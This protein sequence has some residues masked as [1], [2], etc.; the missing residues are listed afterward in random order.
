[1]DGATAHARLGNAASS[2]RS[3]KPEVLIGGGPA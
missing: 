3:G 1:M 2:R